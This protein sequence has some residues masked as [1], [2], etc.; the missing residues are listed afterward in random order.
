[1]VGY[2]S[3]LFTINLVAL[4]NSYISVLI[5][6]ISNNSR[7]SWLFASLI[8]VQTGKA[9]FVW[10]RKLLMDVSTLIEL[11]FD[12]QWDMHVL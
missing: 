9:F 2:F 7:N 3:L 4:K 10:F 8:T 6:R 1:M 5:Q 12:I 11:G